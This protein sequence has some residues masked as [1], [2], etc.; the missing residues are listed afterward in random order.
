M[1]LGDTAMLGIA[2]ATDQGDDIQAKLVVGQGEVGFGFRAVGA[3]VAGQP[4]LGQRRM[5]RVRRVT[6]SRVVTV[7]KLA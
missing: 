5:C 7:R 4:G 1:D 3:V 2:E 6:A